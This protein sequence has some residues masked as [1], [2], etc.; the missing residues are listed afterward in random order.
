MEPALY[1]V[2]VDVLNGNTV[3]LEKDLVY[4]KKPLPVWLGNTLG[5]SATPP[6]PWDKVQVDKQS[7]ILSISGREYQYDYNMFPSQIVNRGKNM[8][9]APMQL[10]LSEG[11]QQISSNV[12]DVKTQ[13]VEVNPNRATSLRTETLGDFTV[14]SNSYV[15]FDGMNW[16]TLKVT[17]DK[18]QAALDGLTF[19][20][21]I[22][23]DW[24]KLMTL[25]HDDYDLKQTGTLP[26]AGWK[27]AAETMPWIGNGDGGIQLFQESTAFWKG[28]KTVEV[29]PDENGRTLIK[30]HFIDVKTELDKPFEISFGWI[31]SPTRPEA[32]DHRDRRFL[33]DSALQYFKTTDNYL[34][35]A[36]AVNPDIKSWITWWQGWWW[37][38]KGYEGNPD[39]GGSLPVPRDDLDPNSGVR[40]FEGIP[41]TYAPYFRLT[42]MFTTNSPW[43]Q[44]FGDEWVPD[45]NKV[46]HSE[47]P[48]DFTYVSQASRSLRDFY[49]WGFNQLL[50]K[51][52]TQAIYYDLSAMR[53][54]TNIYHGAGVKMADGSIEPT[55]NIL[56]M[57]E[58]M[59][60]LYTLLK[61]KNPHG[62]VIYHMSG[63][64]MLPFGSFADEFLDGENLYAQ[65]D[66][67]ENRGYEKILPIDKFRAEYSAQN[68][69][70]PETLF[71]PEFE[72]AQSIR[73]DEW[74]TLGYG[75]MD[76]LLGLILLHDSNVSWGWMDISHITKVYTAIDATGLNGN[77]EFVPYW[78]QKYFS[79]P[80]GV[81]D[82]LY[83]SPDSK[84]VL[85]VIMNTSGKD[86]E[87]N[88]PMALGKST[89][90]SAK[91][92]YPEQSVMVQKN[93]L[94][95]IQVKNNSFVALSFAK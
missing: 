3:V 93:M 6:P 58:S 12:K 54:D 80:S 22:G 23:S 32:K 68:N 86:Q 89:F 51:T 81:Y 35:K 21:P 24:A 31:T 87:I 45:V 83:Q 70:G 79:L 73:K 84:K 82:S 20:I 29:L 7:D 57:R 41:I 52:N 62:L 44:Q 88:L 11:N 33:S 37:K 60:R 36:V 14:S 90:T 61:E 15:E 19:E 39:A 63:E 42:N 56:G 76:Y 26:K 55:F 43:F 17:P 8:L 1:D 10:V 66:R 28:S 78:D 72:R 95:N 4:D 65:L 30:V 40:D 9:A 49:A 53:S 91:A 94:Q 27:G 46:I 5:I 13:W 25:G 64:P 48:Q 75:H 2:K 74:K 92:V 18:K 50:T 67:K 47:D 34:Q 38:A 71:L 85:L 69:F 16:T 77:W 59:K